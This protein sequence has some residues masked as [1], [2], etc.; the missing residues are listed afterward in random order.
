MQRSKRKS[1][2]KSLDTFETCCNLIL[3]LCP[4]NK[5]TSSLYNLI[6]TIDLFYFHLGYGYPIVFSS[7]CILDYCKTNSLFENLYYSFLTSTAHHTQ[8]H[9]MSIPCHKR[10]LIFYLIG[11]IPFHYFFFKHHRAEWIDIYNCNIS[12]RKC[13]IYF[14]SSF[15]II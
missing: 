8:A 4:S 6:E 13:F 9:L 10:M 12:P 5:L 2:T 1:T 3:F 14:K 15:Y 11:L 7:Y